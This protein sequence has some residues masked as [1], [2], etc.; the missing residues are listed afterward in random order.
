MSKTYTETLC[1]NGTCEQKYQVNQGFKSN[2]SVNGC[3]IPTYF[4]CYDKVELNNSIQPVE[5]TEGAYLLN[6]NVYLNKYAKNF[7]KVPCKIGSCNEGTY[8]SMDPRLYSVTSNTYLPLDRV[9]ITGKVKLKDI[10][11]KKYDTYST[12]YVPYEKI[13]DGQI[14]Y[15]IDKSIASSFYKPVY[16]EKCGEQAVLYK[17]PM[18]SMKPEYNRIPTMNTE[19]PTTEDRKSF[20]YG[21]SFLQDTQSHREDLISLQQRKNNQEKWSARWTL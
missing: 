19:N 16:S 21:L 14:A 17:D 2:L 20:P 15:Y 9:P 7:D 6:E 3:E 11:D 13:E 5:E 18:S 12:G 1:D 4:K 8:L 10:Y